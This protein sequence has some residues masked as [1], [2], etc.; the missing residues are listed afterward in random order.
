MDE[1]AG[2][3]VAGGHLLEGV[4]VAG[5]GVDVQGDGAGGRG[6]AQEGGAPLGLHLLP[7]L[8]HLVVVLVHVGDVDADARLDCL[9]VRRLGDQEEVEREGRLEDGALRDD[10]DVD[11][12]VGHR[13]E[14]R[15]RLLVAGRA[16]DDGDVEGDVPQAAGLG[17]SGDE[18]GRLYL[19]VGLAV[20]G[21][22]ER[23]ELLPDADVARGLHLQLAAD[24]LAEAVLGGDVAGDRLVHQEPLLRQVDRHLVLGKDVLLDSDVEFGRGV[25]GPGGY[26][27]HAQVGLV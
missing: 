4:G 27:P 9:A 26:L 15:G 21:G 13:H 25:A 2:G 6:E 22:G 17:D 16:L 20:D 7:L 8:T 11:G 5:G 10:L 18:P 19:K 3:R 1:V 24:R 14:L 23:G 12:G